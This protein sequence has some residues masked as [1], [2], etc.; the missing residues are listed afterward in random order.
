[1]IVESLIYLLA[2]GLLWE[3]MIKNNR[4]FDVSI[5]YFWFSVGSAHVYQYIGE[6]QSNSLN[7]PLVLLIIVCFITMICL[8]ISFSLFMMLLDRQK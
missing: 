4:S 1:M 2:N 3:K 7:Y 8:I 6:R 5:L